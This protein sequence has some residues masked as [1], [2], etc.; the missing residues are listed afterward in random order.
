LNTLWKETWLLLK[1]EITLE[2]RQRTAFNSLI[3]YMFG[4]VFVCYLSFSQR[5][6]NLH[7]V[8]WNTLWWLIVL[9]ASFQ[10]ISKSFLQERE[11]RIYF[12]YQIA[13]PQSVV[14]S[15]ML[16][17]FLM[18]MLIEI[19]GIVAYWA[20]M[21]NPIQN[22][23]MFVVIIL[24]SALCFSTTLT[25]I[26]AIAAKA[27]HNTSLMAVLGFPVILPMLLMLIRAAKNAMDGL[28]WSSNADELLVLSAL[29]LIVITVSMIL[30][31]YLWRS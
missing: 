16:Y 4:A 28:N 6:V 20:V 24:L 10:S 26:S 31:P 5:K 12:Y 7:P 30:F 27:S 19:I 14:L 22:I 25:T 13:N 18:M 29:N 11:E 1:K 8:V 17:N 21:G 15:K 2:W 9:F 23:G 3:L